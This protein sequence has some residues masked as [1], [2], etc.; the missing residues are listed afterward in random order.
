MEPL[1]QDEEQQVFFAALRSSSWRSLAGQS[2]ERSGRPRISHHP[3][4]LL[5]HH[6]RGRAFASAWNWLILALLRL[7][8]AKPAE[9]ASLWPAKAVGIVFE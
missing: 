4:S 5:Q 9:K 7:Q 8:G 2:C 1:P 6:Q 3:V